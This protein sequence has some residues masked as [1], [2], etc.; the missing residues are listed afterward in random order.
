MQGSGKV[1]FETFFQFPKLPKNF[2]SNERLGNPYFEHSSDSHMD[3]EFETSPTFSKPLTL[4]GSEEPLGG[5]RFKSFGTKEAAVTVKLSAL[6]D[7]PF[8]STYEIFKE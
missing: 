8:E 2:N 5:W 4:I 7:L 6:V 3:L 1:L